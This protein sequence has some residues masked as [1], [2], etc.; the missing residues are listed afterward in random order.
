V[1]PYAT[2]LF[3]PDRTGCF[4]VLYPSILSLYYQRY[5]NGQ[6]STMNMSLTIK[7]RRI[8]DMPLERA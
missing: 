5:K 8:F 7:G 4:K 3:I 1:E 2:F 6:F